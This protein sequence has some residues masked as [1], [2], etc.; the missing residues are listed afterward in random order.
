LLIAACF[1]FLYHLLWLADQHRLTLGH[2]FAVYGLV[3]VYFYLLQYHA[4]LFDLW[5]LHNRLP[6]SPQF[7]IFH[8]CLMAF[9][10]SLFVS[11]IGI[12]ARYSKTCAES[13]YLKTRLHTI[14]PA[15]HA[16]LLHLAWLENPHMP[17]KAALLSTS[18]QLT[19]GQGTHVIGINTGQSGLS[20][21]GALV[22]ILTLVIT[23]HFI[24]S[25]EASI[26]LNVLAGTLF[27]STRILQLSCSQAIRI[28]LYCVC[29][30]TSPPAPFTAALV[31]ENLYF[32]T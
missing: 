14:P 20:R 24:P 17:L 10:S 7:T 4:A 25:T 22:L 15:L 28:A 21:W 29:Q 6:N 2:S 18:A 27:I 11:T 8:A 12:A 19:L 3:F 32:R 13:R 1:P 31:K 5:A 30:N 16:Q 23:A 26:I 9:K